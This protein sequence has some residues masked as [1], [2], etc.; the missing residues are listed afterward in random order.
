MDCNTLSFPN[1][2]KRKEE[3]ISVLSCH[4]MPEQYIFQSPRHRLIN[5]HQIKLYTTMDSYGEKDRS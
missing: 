2:L 4:D 1:G 3:Y 5:G